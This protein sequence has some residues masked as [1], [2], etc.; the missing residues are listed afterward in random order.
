MT[1]FTQ[2]QLRAIGNADE[3]NKRLTAWQ[4]ANKTTGLPTAY[5]LGVECIGYAVGAYGCSGSLFR[6]IKTGELFGLAGRG[7]HIYIR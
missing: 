6:D 7:Y 1:Q 5:A 2:K 4:T 3:F